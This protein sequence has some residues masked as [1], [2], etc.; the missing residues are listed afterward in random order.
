MQPTEDSVFQDN[1]KTKIN[2]YFNTDYYAG[3]LKLKSCS[4]IKN[5]NSDTTSLKHLLN[6]YNKQEILDEDNQWY[7]KRCKDHKKALIKRS[8]IRTPQILIVQI[9]RFK[10]QL[11]HG[12]IN[13]YKI[14]EQVDFEETLDL[15]PYLIKEAKQS[16]T[17][18]LFGVVN[19]Y[20]DIG[21]GHYTAFA[22]NFVNNKWY[23][24]D[25]SEVEQIKPNGI[26]TK[27]AYILFYQ[28]N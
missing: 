20:G 14:N 27:A 16:A 1:D 3:D 25:D 28:K 4:T 12:F 24:F 11:S 13:M 8:F 23:D 22:R 26:N 2:V 9:K 5:N 18:S 15:T 10:K 6:L 21:G 19:H 7:C 17:Y